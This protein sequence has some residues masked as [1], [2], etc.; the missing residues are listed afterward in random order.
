MAGC[1]STTFFYNRLDTL[2]SW[3]VDDFVTLTKAQEG[4]FEVRLDALLA[5]HRQEELPRYVAFLDDINAMLDREITPEDSAYLLEGFTDAAE[6]L[7]QASLDMMLAFGETLSPAQRLEFIAA[8]KVDQQEL[9]DEYLDRSD[10]EFQEA[11]QE[12]MADR[13][14]EFTG[15]LS[16]AQ[17]AVIAEAAKDFVRLDALWLADRDRWIADVEAIVTANEPDWAAQVR[18]VLNDRRSQRSADYNAG[19]EQNAEVSQSIIVAIINDRTPEQDRRLRRNLQDYR[20]DFLQLIAEAEPDD[21][22][23]LVEEPLSVEG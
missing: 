14:S 15:R 4:D 10:E 3:Y 8:L 19:F 18:A 11:N 23:P 7:Q 13:L 1:S 5:W 16:K 9:K 6:R 22:P 20:E 12:R 2:I 17:K 21:E